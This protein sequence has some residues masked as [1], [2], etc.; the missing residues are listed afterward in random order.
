MWLTVFVLYFNRLCSLTL[1]HL[2]LVKP[3]EAE[4][5]SVIIAV[6]MQVCLI[7]CSYILFL[8]DIVLTS[9]YSIQ[10]EIAAENYHQLPVLL[11]C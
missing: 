3:L 4:L 2:M 7:R 1:T 8:R 6:K 5:Q 9:I 11:C 10:L